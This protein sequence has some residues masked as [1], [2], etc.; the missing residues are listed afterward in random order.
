MQKFI[1]DIQ[2]VPASRPRVT[3]W[4]TY[5]PKRYT[6]FREAMEP[7]VEKIK[8]NPTD[9]LLRVKI[10]FHVGMPKSWSKKKRNRLDGKYCTNNADLDNYEK[11]ILDSLEGTLFVNDN[12]IVD[13]HARKFYSSDPR[14]VYKQQEIKC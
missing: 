1:F 13:M 8:I 6:E 10:D 11:A 14:I 5:Y 2:P 4:S 7:I 3:R 12:Q 9:S